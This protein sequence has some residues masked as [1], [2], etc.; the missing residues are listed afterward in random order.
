MRKRKANNTVFPVRAKSNGVH[1][2][3]WAFIN[4]AG[5][6]TVY[7]TQEKAERI[8]AKWRPT[9]TRLIRDNYI[10]PGDKLHLAFTGHRNADGRPKLV[11]VTLDHVTGTTTV[12]K[13]HDTEGN[14]YTKS[15]MDLKK[16]V[17]TINDATLP[18]LDT[19][20]SIHPGSKKSI[21]Q[22]KNQYVAD[23]S[24]NNKEPE[25]EPPE[26]AKQPNFLDFLTESD[27][28]LSSPDVDEKVIPLPDATFKQESALVEYKEEFCTYL[29]SQV[30][31]IENISHLSA[32]DKLKLC[33]ANLSSL[34]SM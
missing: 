27:L 6:R 16:L 12:F 23:F 3:Q 34:L 26:E 2:N 17:A 7:P 15:L 13:L 21:D 32:A 31:A 30:A 22:L 19:K 29:E 5:Q 24:S 1:T 20:N 28:E 10:K 8:R 25:E 9:I 18:A 33:K 11:P 14:V 4:P